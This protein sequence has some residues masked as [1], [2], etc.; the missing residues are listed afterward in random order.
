ML[1]GSGAVMGP[2]IRKLV[3]I[4][5]KLL[6]PLP[7]DIVWEVLVDSKLDTQATKI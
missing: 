5:P 3:E 1:E 4:E 6:L 7:E 2:V